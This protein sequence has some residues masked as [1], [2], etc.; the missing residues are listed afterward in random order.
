MEKLLKKVESPTLL[1]DIIGVMPGVYHKCSAV[2]FILSVREG[3]E[4]NPVFDRTLH[5][6]SEPADQSWKA[7]EIDMSRYVNQ[8]TELRFAVDPAGDTAYDWAVWLNP[9]WSAKNKSAD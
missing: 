5:P 1:V 3:Q 8:T 6:M 9:R 7:I 4:W 2:R